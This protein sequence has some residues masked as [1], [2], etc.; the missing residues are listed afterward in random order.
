MTASGGTS[1][2]NA[3]FFL[4]SSSSLRD[5]RAIIAFGR[6][7]TERSSRTDCC[8]GF[9]FCSPT[10]P[11]IGTRVVWMKQMLVFPTS[12][13]SCL[14]A[15]RKG[16][17]SMSPTVPPISIMQTSALSFSATSLISLL[18]SSVMCGIIWTVLPK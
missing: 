15:S 12:M 16:M 5:P 8:V 6:I 17:P 9:V 13:P 18:I 11:N 10:V 4:M 3:I 2:K 1:Q 7:P 14:T